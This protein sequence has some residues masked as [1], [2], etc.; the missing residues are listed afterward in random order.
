MRILELAAMVVLVVSDCNPRPVAKHVVLAFA[1][2]EPKAPAAPQECKSVV[3]VALDGVRWQ[4]IFYGSDPDLAERQRVPERS[5]VDLTP[6]L[7]RWMT[8]G[9]ALGTDDAQIRAT[10]PHFVSLPGYTEMLTGRSPACVDNDCAPPHVRTFAD[11]V[12]RGDEAA[13]ITSWEAIGRVAFGDRTHGEMTTGRHGTTTPMAFDASILAEGDAS[14]PAPGMGDFRP[15]A[16]TARL[17]LSFVR[18][19]SPN[20]FFVELGEPDEYAHRNDY[21]RY[22]DSLRAADDFLARLEETLGPRAAIFVTAD[23]GRAKNFRDHGREF[24]ESARV[25]LV[26]KGA[27]VAS[28]GIVRSPVVR[29]LADIAPTMRV[30]LHMPKDEDANAGRPIEELITPP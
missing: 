10:G 8:N 19:H 12:A 22:L 16:L 5:A 9:S 24:P 1:A 25:W 17:A 2:S 21:R 11:E 15:D 4:E 28:R 14:D 3:L 26:A 30:L 27:G 13:V 29:R 7:H 20:F 18:T 6:T 23:H